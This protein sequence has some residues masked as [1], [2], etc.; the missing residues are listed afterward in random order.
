MYYA[1]LRTHL[2]YHKIQLF[3]TQ[4]LLVFY[5][6]AKPGYHDRE[7]WTTTPPVQTQKWL[8]CTTAPGV[9]NYLAAAD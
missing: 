5:I 2:K 7:E 1:I 9:D 6:F 8:E 4:T 3:E